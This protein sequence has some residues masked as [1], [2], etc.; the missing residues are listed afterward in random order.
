MGPESA[1]V[2]SQTSSSEQPNSSPRRLIR[3]PPPVVTGF[4]STFVS[5]PLCIAD[6]GIVQLLNP[7]TPILPEPSKKDF[8]RLA[9]A[10]RSRRRS[11]MSATQG[12]LPGSVGKAERPG[13]SSTRGSDSEVDVINPRSPLVQVRRSRKEV[14][15]VTC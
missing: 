11:P 7:R 9:A 4:T 15:G 10:L 8:P 13:S 12:F 3:R 6:G 1:D 5:A 2:V 14:P